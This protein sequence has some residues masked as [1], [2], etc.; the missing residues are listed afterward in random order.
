LFPTTIVQWQKR[1]VQLDHNMRQRRA[2]ERI[3]G[4]REG[5]VVPPA[6]EN[7]QQSG[8]QQPS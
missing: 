7:A 4:G 3:L 8:G 2:E 5:N 1:V 6:M